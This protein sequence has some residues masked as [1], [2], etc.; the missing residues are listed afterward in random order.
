M[1]KCLNEHLTMFESRCDFVS[2][3]VGSTH[4]GVGGSTPYFMEVFRIGCKS[5]WISPMSSWL[6]HTRCHTKWEE[7]WSVSSCVGRLNTGGKGWQLQIAE[8]GIYLTSRVLGDMY[9]RGILWTCM[10][11]CV[12]NCF[13]CKTWKREVGRLESTLLDHGKRVSHV[14]KC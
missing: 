5:L 7:E 1:S 9:S 12:S 6:H 14:L 10:P 4:F 3:Y 11:S 8:W 2:A 13:K